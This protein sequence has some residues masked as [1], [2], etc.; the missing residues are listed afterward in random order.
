MEE[1]LESVK[2]AL[3]LS[4]ISTNGGLHHHEVLSSCEHLCSLSPS[5]R[6]HTTGKEMVISFYYSVSDGGQLVVPWDL[7]PPP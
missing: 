6:H 5:L 3:G 2:A 1:A 7:S 4:A